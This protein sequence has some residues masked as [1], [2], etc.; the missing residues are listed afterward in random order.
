MD[1]DGRFVVLHTSSADPESAPRLEGLGGGRDWFEGPLHRQLEEADIDALLDGVPRSVCRRIEALESTSEESEIRQLAACIDNARQKTA[2]RDILMQFRSGDR[3]AAL[4]RLA[5][6]KGRLELA[7]G[8]AQN[9]A[10]LRVVP[11]DPEEGEK[12][13]HFIRTADYADWMLFPHP[14]QEALVDA[15]FRG[16]AKLLGVSGS[17]KTCVVVRRAVALAERYGSEVL[18]LTLNRPLASLI[19]NLVDN[20]CHAKPIRDLITV[21]PF[22]VLCQEYLRE[23]EPQNTKLYDDRTWKTEEHIDEIWREYYRCET[24]NRDAACM[25]QVNDAL[26]AQ[27][28]DAER[29]VREE[30]DWIRSAVPP[31]DREQYLGM[32]RKGR[33]Y[34]LVQDQREALLTGLAG[35]EEKLREV[36]VTDHLGIATA[37][38]R[39]QDRLRPRYRAILIDECQDFG[40]IEVELISRLAEDRPDS[41]FLCGDAAQHASWKHQ[42]LRQAGVSVPGARSRRLAQNY[43]NSRDVLAAAHLLLEENMTDEMLDR[44]DDFEILDPRFANFGGQVPV[45]L[46]AD[47]LE[48]E[49]AQAVEFARSEIRSGEA[50]GGRVKAC[51]AFCGYSAYEVGKFAKSSSVPVLE[52]GLDTAGEESLF[53]SG[54]EQTKGFEFQTMVIVNVRNGVMPNPAM[55]PRERCRDLC[56]LYVAMT[57]ATL[58]LVLSYSE[59]PSPYIVQAI[60]KDPRRFLRDSWSSYASAAAPSFGVPQR[61]E[62]LRT[63]GQGVSDGV[64]HMTGEEFL[65][66]GSALGVSRDLAAKLRL[67]VTGREDRWGTPRTW[68]TLFRLAEDARTFRDVRRTL[69]PKAVSNELEQL[70]IRLSVS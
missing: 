3:E 60:A 54:L 28:I 55:P 16:A 51:A 68:S 1:E 53:F 7:D 56:R 22:F 21:R 8:T 58:Q 57:R 67:H 64:G 48:R 59:E 40:T 11:V 35:W 15:E 4:V 62:I 10:E 14:D 19:E 31:G 17:G 2:V 25:Q 66:S 5:E 69:G 30:F 63:R 34:P 12:F 33:S 47:S 61:L 39:H 70:M 36:G 13:K 42:S 27:R 20:C 9:G 45:V 18:V 23:F 29:Y 24:N 32:E 6:Y 44:Q 26:L 37:L 43:R 52:E 41:L 65:Y 46:E 38:R 49:I 50:E